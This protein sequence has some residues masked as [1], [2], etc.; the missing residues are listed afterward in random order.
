SRRPLTNEMMKYAI[1]DTHYLDPIYRNMKFEIDGRNLNN[2]FSHYIS[3]ILKEEYYQPNYKKIAEKIILK[4]DAT[5][6]YHAL[7]KEDEEKFN[8]IQDRLLLIVKIREK[9]AMVNNIRRGAIM[10]DDKVLFL[11]KIKNINEN[12]VKSSFIFKSTDKGFYKNI[13]LNIID[14]KLGVYI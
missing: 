7:N 11:A 8:M 4:F 6:S 9:I 13:L 12:H 2:N 14:N 1:L 10:S 5:I 3:N